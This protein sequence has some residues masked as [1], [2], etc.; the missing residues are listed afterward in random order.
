MTNPEVDEVLAVWRPYFEGIKD[1]E[2]EWQKLVAGVEPKATGCGPVYEISNPIEGRPGESFAIADMRELEFAEPHYHTNGEIEIYVALTGM[3]TVVVGGKE[4][5]L[6]PGVMSVTPPD[7][8]HFVVPMHDL[9]IAV[10]NMPPFNATNVV[11]LDP[12]TSNPTV[13][14]DAEQL[15]RLRQAA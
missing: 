8:A 7:T 1:W 14:F 5:P 4:A 2:H 10:I 6:R 15:A 3:G 11:N 12:K 9:V 13:G